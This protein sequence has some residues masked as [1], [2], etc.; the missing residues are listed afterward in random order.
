MTT[1]TFIFSFHVLANCIKSKQKEKKI[2]ILFEAINIE[3]RS[4]FT[5]RVLLKDN[6][7]KH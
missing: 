1:K 7:P 3:E 6:L 5:G 4:P 2:D